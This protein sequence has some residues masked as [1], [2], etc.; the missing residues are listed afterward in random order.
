MKNKRD[1]IRDIDPKYLCEVLRSMYADPHD[2]I[3]VNDVYTRLN[4]LPIHTDDHAAF[5][6]DNF[7][8]IVFV[9]LSW[10]GIEYIDIKEI[11]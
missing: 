1:V 8:D 9:L 11:M 10:D 3:A 4:N 2:I 7:D 6:R 5:I